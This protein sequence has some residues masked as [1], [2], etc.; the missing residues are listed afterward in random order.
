M[1]IRLLFFSTLSSLFI[2]VVQDYSYL[3][4]IDFRDC[5]FL[6]ET[7]DFST[8]LNLERLNLEGCTSL[9]KIHNSIGCLD[10]LVFL[11]L[12]FCSNLKSL[13]SSLRLRSLQTLLLTGCSKLEKFPNIEDRMTSLERVCLNETAIEEL[14]SSIENLVGLQVLTLSFCRNLSSIPSS[15]YMLQHLKHLLLEG[16]SN[17]KNFP[18]NVGNERQPIFSMVSLKLNYGS[19]W[20]P[21]LTCLDLKNCNLL[22]VD[23]LMNPDCFSMLK[24]LDLSGNSFFR[25]PTSI[26][27]FK[28]L[29]RLKLVNCKWLR[30]IPQL[31]PSIKCIGARDCISLERFSQLTRVFKISKA[32]R[33]KRLHDLDFSNCHKLAENPLS[34]LTSIALANTSLDEVCLPIHILSDLYM[35]VCLVR[36]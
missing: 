1:L 21:R 16:C 8:I 34:S 33:L 36:K 22:E 20:F 11:S 31:P 3:K 6:T 25:L 10:K 14:P 32:E 9:V 7:P 15:I 18:E 4:H 12:E 24:D 13:S 2:S 5:E 28:K 23:F 26:C 29:R 17:L 19:K 27:S 35:H 30:E